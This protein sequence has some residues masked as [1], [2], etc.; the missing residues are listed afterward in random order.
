MSLTSKPTP[1]KVNQIRNKRKELVNLRFAHEKYNAHLAYY[2]ARQKVTGYDYKA[3]AIVFTYAAL[4]IVGIS[5][6]FILT[7]T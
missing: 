6:V 5:S 1:A 2:E 7:A 3:L 4:L